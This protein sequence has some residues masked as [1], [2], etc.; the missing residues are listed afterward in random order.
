MKF[1][2][3]PGGNSSFTE[4]LATVHYMIGL[5]IDHIR[6]WITVFASGFVSRDG[7]GDRGNVHRARTRPPILIRVRVRLTDTRYHTTTAGM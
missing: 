3:V 2:S 5:A 1:F 7:V 6:W 4:T